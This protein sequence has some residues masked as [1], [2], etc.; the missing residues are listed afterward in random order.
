M[1]TR[2]WAAALVLG[3]GLT[4]VASRGQSQGQ[5]QDQ[6]MQSNPTTPVGGVGAGQPMQMGKPAIPAGP[7]KISFGD[8]SSEWT[9]ATLAALPHKRMT[10]YNE[11]AKAN[12]TYGGVELID[13]LMPLGVPAKPHGKDL[14]LYLVAEGSDGYK[15]VYSIGE[16]T[17]D[18]HDGMVL[19]A[20]SLDNK[21][22]I[23][24]GPLQLVITGDARPARWVRNLVAIRVREAE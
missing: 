10:V 18:V 1:A 8:K 21:P 4:A 5:N 22:L 13:L 9:P 2:V 19:L 20:D 7:L 15:V 24:S 17:P 14:R 3:M 16:V 6:P 12:Q 11:H 23:E